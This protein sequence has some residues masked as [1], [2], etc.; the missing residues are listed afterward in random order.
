[1]AYL[2]AKRVGICVPLE[3]KGT[4]A[5][6]EGERMDIGKQ[7]PVSA[8]NLCF[9]PLYPLIH[10][11]PFSL[12]CQV[13]PLLCSHNIFYMHECVPSIHKFNKEILNYYH[14]SGTRL[15]PR[16]KHE[17]TEMIRHLTLKKLMGRYMCT[18]APLN[19]YYKYL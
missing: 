9:P 1:M 6:E 17:C 18:L 16:S 19:F 12:E 10:S 13:L 7:L 4:I 5:M 14:V 15:S 3:I 11:L 8:T 2:K